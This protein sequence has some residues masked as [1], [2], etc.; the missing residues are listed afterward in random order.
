LT[1]HLNEYDL[2]NVI[3]ILQEDK[4][5]TYIDPKTK[6]DEENKGDQDKNNIALNAYKMDSTKK[7]IISDRMPDDSNNRDTAL[8]YN[9]RTEIDNKINNMY[10]RLYDEENLNHKKT[11][12]KPMGNV[13]QASDDLIQDAKTLISQSIVEA[14]PKNKAALIKQARNKIK[15]IINIQKNLPDLNSGGSSGSIDFTGGDVQLSPTSSTIPSPMSSTKSSPMLSTIPSPMLSTKSSTMSSPESHKNEY[16]VEIVKQ[17]LNDET[18]VDNSIPMATN[19]TM[20]TYASMGHD[21]KL[22]YPAL[23]GEYGFYMTINEEGQY[24]LVILNTKEQYDAY[25]KKYGLEDE[26]EEEKKDEEEE[27]EEKDA[28]GG[29]KKTKKHKRVKYNTRR[30]SKLRLNKTQKRH[31]RKHNKTKV[32]H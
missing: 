2:A 13:V 1:A 7:K 10:D 31:R 30:T 20:T 3:N 14:D 15:L 32:N 5:I 17:S 11:K 29:K 8:Q 25:I 23:F 16:E 6:N 22:S 12:M 21:I 24:E 19:T 9:N 26:D 27:K 4:L 28:I 18:K